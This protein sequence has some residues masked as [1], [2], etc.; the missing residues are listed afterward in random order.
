[1]IYI[2]TSAL[3]KTLISESASEA[4]D[5][6]LSEATSVI[7]SPLVELEIHV[8]LRG[9]FLGGRYRRREYS[10]LC[11]NFESLK[12]NSPFSFRMTSGAIFN[13]ALNQHRETE[14]HCRS[15]DRLH[16]AAMEELGIKRLMTHDFRQAD[17]ARERGIEVLMPGLT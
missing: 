5:Q 14:I 3:I 7:I 9:W 13:A 12:S 10:A 11:E 15:L 1:M 6:S 2:D 4:V 8:Q 17:A 16:L